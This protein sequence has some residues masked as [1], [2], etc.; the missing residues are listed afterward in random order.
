MALTERRTWCIMLLLTLLCIHLSSQTNEASLEPQRKAQDTALE[1]QSK[2]RS[3]QERKTQDT[4]LEQQS[5]EG[6]E[7]QRKLHDTDLTQQSRGKDEPQRKTQNSSPKQWG[8]GKD[9]PQRKTQNS[10]PKQWGRGRRSEPSSR[11]RGLSAYK[12]YRWYM[13]LP[14]FLYNMCAMYYVVPDCMDEMFGE[15]FDIASLI[16]EVCPI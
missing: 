16:A 8:R 7:E 5:R 14:P 10:S 15:E 2:E 13:N 3:G 6:S 12:N 9:E 1:Q 11:S 4:T